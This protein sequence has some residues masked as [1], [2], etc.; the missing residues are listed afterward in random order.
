MTG[1]VTLPT[2]RLILRE[3]TESDWRATLT[4]QSDPRY[5]RFYSWTERTEPEVRDFVNVFVT[6]QKEQ[7]RRKFQLAVTQKSDGR[8]LGSGG[9]R[10]HQAEERQADLGYEL[11]P[12]VW[13]NGF[14]SEAVRELLRFGFQTLG[15]HRIS[16]ECIAEDAASIRVMEKNGMRRE[17]HL[18]ENTRFKG[19]W[20]DTLTY[21]ILESEWQEAP[22]P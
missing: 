4:Y 21:A 9:I 15:M 11:D 10:V 20:W 3:F 17:A 14:A 12:R 19:R 18:R 6:Q 13:G 1:P 7:P 16:A 22:P 8:L 5:L 2:Q